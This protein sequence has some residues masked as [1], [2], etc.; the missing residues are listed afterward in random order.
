MQI[1]SCKTTFVSNN[2]IKFHLHPSKIE[3]SSN[4]KAKDV[5]NTSSWVSIFS[6]CIPK[7]M[8][9][10]NNLNGTRRNHSG[11]ET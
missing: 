11:K 10:N 2:C 4:E 6:G 3:A 9:F 5:I 1:N 7:F 8:L